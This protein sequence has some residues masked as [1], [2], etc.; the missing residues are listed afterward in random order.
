MMLSFLFHKNI[1]ELF[2]SSQIN[3]ENSAGECVNEKT[4]NFKHIC[5]D[6]NKKITSFKYIYLLIFS[7]SI[8]LLPVTPSIC[9][10]NVEI[11]SITWIKNKIALKNTQALVI[12][13]ILKYF[14]L[15]QSSAFQLILR[16]YCQL[17]KHS[18]A[19]MSL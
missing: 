9:V 7:I 6:T 13:C 12:I 3:V 2:E 5:T 19:F 15:L 11:N 4:P 17:L 16:M 1:P 8:P 10:Y 14:S 18:F